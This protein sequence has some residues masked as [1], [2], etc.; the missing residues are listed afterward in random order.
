MLTPLVPSLVLFSL[1]I[2]YQAWQQK[3][4]EYEY[5]PDPEILLAY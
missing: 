1:V 5:R 4:G 2:N 3:K